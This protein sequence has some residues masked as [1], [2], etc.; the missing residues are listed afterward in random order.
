MVRTNW[1]PRA[2]D[3]YLYGLLGQDQT[4]DTASRSVTASLIDP[5]TG[6]SAGVNLRIVAPPPT[7]EPVGAVTAALGT[8]RGE[9]APILSIAGSTEDQLVAWPELHTTQVFAPIERSPLAI[10]WDPKR[11]PKTRR[12]A[13]L[14][15]GE[16]SIL[17]TS[18]AMYMA[19]LL[20]DE[21]VK[22]EQLD[23]SFSG[24]FGRFVRLEGQAAQQVRV[25]SDIPFLEAELAE[26][27]RPLR[28]ELLD[29]A[30]WRPYD[31][32][33]VIRS[34]RVDEL[35]PCLDELV[36]MMQRALTNYLSSPQVVNGRISTLNQIYGQPTTSRRADDAALALVVFG[37]V[38]NGTDVTLGDPD[39]QRLS[40]FVRLVRPLLART[41]RPLPDDVVLE[42]LATRR[43]VRPGIGFDPR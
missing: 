5:D 19:Y 10:A 12:I 37:L 17:Y 30:G 43:F 27:R 25:T 7:E 36:P 42:T 28:F 22:R 21:Q 40:E 14:Q 13:D 34:D 11:Y 35:S 39:L 29:D 33:L 23:G 41:D 3:G 24:S 38:G 4:V 9:S 15:R 2:E 26:W 20:R 31:S 16:V 1:F 6:L 18:G 8:L 32:P